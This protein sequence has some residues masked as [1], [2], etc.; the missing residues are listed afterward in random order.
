MRRVEVFRKSCYS[1]FP[2]AKLPGV[3]FRG[4]WQH[5]HDNAIGLDASVRLILKLP[6]VPEVFGRFVRHDW[7]GKIRVTVNG[8]ETDCFDLYSPYRFEQCIPLHRGDAGK[9]LTIEITPLG[10]NPVS[11][12]AQMVFLGIFV[13]R[14]HASAIPGSAPPAPA[15][16]P[17]GA[18]HF[19]ELQVHMVDRYRQS[20]KERGVSAEEEARGRWA[21]Y[22]MR[23]REMLV[24]AEPGQRILDI[25][26]GYQMSGFIKKL[27]VSNHIGYWAQDIDPRAVAHTQVAL[28][29]CGLDPDQVRQGTNTDLPYP[30]GFF[31][32]VFSSHCLE[33]SD[34]IHRTFAEIHRIVRPGGY[35]FFAVPFGY[36]D[37]EEHT[38]ALDPEG[39][40][41]LTQAPGF[42]V[43][44]QHIGN[45]YTEARHDLVVVGRRPLS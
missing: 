20:V 24:Y 8:R 25:G 32:L 26:A 6:G 22:E 40:V 19:H 27:L 31:D 11:H 18:Q 39:W 34:D 45:I 38:Y 10:R 35:L 15:S 12:S 37:A 16:P 3:S 23:F 1:Y 44:N 41:A 42:E 9:P 2:Y 5:L 33:H 28:R 21:K 4:S 43:V 14:E 30:D 36:D 17:N 29:S 13:D 7:S